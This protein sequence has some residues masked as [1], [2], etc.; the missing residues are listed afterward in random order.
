[1]SKKVEE[2]K[3]GRVSNLTHLRKKLEQDKAAITTLAN[4]Q[5]EA[6]KAV[7]EA[8]KKTV[9]DFSAT[10]D[11]ILQQCDELTAALDIRMAAVDAEI[12]AISAESLTEG[13]FEGEYLVLKEQVENMYSSIRMFQSPMEKSPEEKPTIVEATDET[14]KTSEAV[15]SPVVSETTTVEEPTNKTPEYITPESF[16]VDTA[17]TV[18]DET[19]E[20]VGEETAD[21]QALN[22]YDSIHDDIFGEPKVEA[23][24]VIK[25]VETSPVAPT[26][27]TTDG[28]PNTLQSLLANAKK[29][30]IS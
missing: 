16:T 13:H 5:R 4:Q 11:A 1:M 17:E 19:A 6:L 10:T 24:A 9:E 29:L 2:F 26:L 30:N 7:T 25:V 20:T 27:S 18:G 22:D 28:E 23:S 14:G 3:E 12:N 15:D 21:T 8:T